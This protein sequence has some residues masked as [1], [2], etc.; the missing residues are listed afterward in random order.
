M[1]LDG[2]RIDI[3]IEK[4]IIVERF[5]KRMR[6]IMKGK[7]NVI[8]INFASDFSSYIQAQL[9]IEQHGIKTINRA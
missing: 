7:S 8:E 9:Y 6:T 4:Y 1:G 2:D 5:P 3:K